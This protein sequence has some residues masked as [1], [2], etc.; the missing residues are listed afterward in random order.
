MYLNLEKHEPRLPSPILS[1]FTTAHPRTAT[2]NSPDDD[3]DVSPLSYAQFSTLIQQT[4]DGV[5]LSDLIV[6][7]RSDWEAQQ[8][9]LRQGG[10]GDDGKE[11]IAAGL[12]DLGIQSEIG[13]RVEKV[14]ASIE[15]TYER[16]L[17]VNREELAERYEKELKKLRKRVVDLE[18]QKQGFKFF[19]KRKGISNGTDESNSHQSTENTS[20][21]EALGAA[22][23]FRANNADGSTLGAGDEPL[24]QAKARILDLETQVSCLKQILSIR[25]TDR[26]T[27]ITN[28]PPSGAHVFRSSSGSMFDSISNPP[29]HASPLMASET[30]R[31][32]ANSRVRVLVPALVVP[33]RRTSN[34]VS[35][36]K[37][38]DIFPRLTTS[39]LISET[40]SFRWVLYITKLGPNFGFVL[41]HLQRHRKRHAVLS[42]RQL[43]LILRPPM[44]R[45]EI[46]HRQPFPERPVRE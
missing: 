20:L 29:R 21:E 45:K 13:V 36:P 5:A 24:A 10:F 40:A 14:K 27:N 41:R 6:I 43:P 8:Q 4:L 9:R 23:C 33:S 30:P 17:K 28:S 38:G 19:L 15:N 12:Y 34:N 22:T 35:L 42:S 7:K 37:A 1:D 11:E 44:R 32:I 26:A 16:L 25:L 46:L 2:T 39:W 31:I 18:I 3:S